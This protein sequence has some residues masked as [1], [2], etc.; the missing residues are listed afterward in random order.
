M[1]QGRTMDEAS[2]EMLTHNL[3]FE[4]SGDAACLRPFRGPLHLQ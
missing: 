2:A 1:G 3:L 4:L